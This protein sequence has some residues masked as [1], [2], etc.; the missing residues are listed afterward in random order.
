MKRKYLL[1]GESPFHESRSS[2]AS[3]GRIRPYRHLRAVG[4]CNSCTRCAGYGWIAC[5]HNGRGPVGPADHDTRVRH[6]NDSGFVGQ[7]RIDVELPQLGSSHTSSETR[8]SVASTLP[9]QS[10][11]DCGTGRAASRPASSGTMS[12]INNSFSRGSAT[13]TGRANISTAVPP[14]PNRDDRAE[15]LILPPRRASARVRWVAG[16]IGSTATPSIAASGP[17]RNAPCR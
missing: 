13:R 5:D 4:D 14:A 12:R 7:Q 8:S 15:H 17:C 9:S 3:S 1:S 11:E 10:A 2:C 16:P 6:C